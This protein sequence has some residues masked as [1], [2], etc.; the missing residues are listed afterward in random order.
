MSQETLARRV[1]VSSALIGHIETGYTRRVSRAIV[2]AIAAELGVVPEALLRLGQE[3]SRGNIAASL[4]RISS[5]LERL[6]GRSGTAFAEFGTTW[7]QDSI[8]SDL[9]MWVFEFMRKN[10]RLAARARAVLPPEAVAELPTHYR[11]GVGFDVSGLPPQLALDTRAELFHG[12]TDVA[13]AIIDALRTGTADSPRDANATVLFTYQGYDLFAYVEPALRAELLQTLGQTLDRGWNVLHLLRS[14]SLHR[15][16]LDITSQAVELAGRKGRYVAKYFADDPDSSTEFDLLIIPG[17]CT[18]QL[19]ST[20]SGGPA[21]AALKLYDPTIQRQMAAVFRKSEASAVELIDTYPRYTGLLRILQSS[22]QVPA[23]RYQIKPGPALATVPNSLWRW[24]ARKVRE[25]LDDGPEARGAL[26]LVDQYERA[27]IK[28]GHL[29]ERSLTSYDCYDLI[30]VSALDDLVLGMYDRN[31]WLVARAQ[32]MQPDSRIPVRFRIEHLERL[33]YLLDRYEH[34]HLGLAYPER[35]EEPLP[36]NLLTVRCADQPQGRSA[37]FVQV[38]PEHPEGG[39]QDGFDAVFREARI[40]GAFHGY[41]S[42]LWE[43]P[44]AVT[45]RA[46]VQKILTEKLGQAQHLDTRQARQRRGPRSTSP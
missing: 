8:D 12:W 20:Q 36:R 40:V 26:D 3:T 13:R 39:R 31:D 24:S 21:D 45:N 37:V 33:I 34:F 10:S 17:Y 46:A 41:F 42:E 1:G 4:D 15:R 44:G 27:M 43:G 2:E 6:A 7:E 14:S 30:S 16:Y 19:W 25:T 5:M 28:R 9:S 18:M 11:V 32:D 22:D 38:W 35:M 23:H 29:L